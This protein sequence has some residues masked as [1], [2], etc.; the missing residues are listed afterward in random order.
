[1]HLPQKAERVWTWHNTDVKK[2]IF[3]IDWQSSEGLNRL[4]MALESG[5]VGVI[6]IGRIPALQ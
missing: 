5:L 3:E 1:M 4:A 2:G 6:D